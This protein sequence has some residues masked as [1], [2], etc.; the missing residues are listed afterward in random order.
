MA[1]N[2]KNMIGGI[3]CDLIKVFYCVNHGILLSK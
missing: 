2:N 3:F 1:L